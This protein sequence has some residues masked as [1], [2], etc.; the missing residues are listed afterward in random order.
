MKILCY[1]P[2]TIWQLHALWEV[3]ILRAMR[4]RGYTVDYVLCDSEYRDCD[5]F[6]VST[7]GYPRPEMA[8]NLC[9][10]RAA[11]FMHQME[12][13]YHWLGRY[14]TLAE[15]ERADQWVQTL[16]P[17]SF[18]EAVYG[19]WTLGHWVQSSVYTHFRINAFDL[20]DPIQQHV[21][22][23]FLY[24]ALV[25][26]FGISRLVDVSQPD[27]VLLFNGRMSSTRV[28]LEI[29]KQKGIPVFCHE[30]GVLTE[31]MS[32]IPN[33][34][35]TLSLKVFHRYW[36]LWQDLPLR[37]HQIQQAFAY[38]SG[39]EQGK[40]LNWSPFNPPPS[41]D[42]MAVYKF[43]A[44]DPQQPV[45]VFFPS[46][47]DEVIAEK[48]QM[49]PLASQ[50]EWIQRAIDYVLLHPHIQLVIRAHPNIIN[51]VLARHG[52]PGGGS[53]SHELAFFEE[54]AA[55]AYPNIRVILPDA[56]LSSYSLMNIATAGIAP[57]STT[58]LELAMKG[59]A[60][61][62]GEASMLAGAAC[63]HTLRDPEAFSQTLDS[64]LTLSPGTVN[65]DLMRHACRLVYFWTQR[66]NI[67]FPLIKMHNVEKGELLYHH[68]DELLPGREMHLDR[69]C[70]MLMTG[71][72][73]LT[74]S[75]YDRI[76]DEQ[77]E[78]AFFFQQPVA[79]VS[80][81]VLP[82]AVGTGWECSMLPRV[83]VVVL[84]HAQSEYLPEA[85]HSLLAQTWREFEVII[86]NLGPDP[87]V[88]RT[89]QHLMA[90]YP[91]VAMCML[92]QP[93][94]S[95]VALALN[96]AVEQARGT[97]ILILPAQDQLSP[98]Y[99]EHC[100]A[101]LDA[102]P[103]RAIAYPR[104]R[105]VTSR[106]LQSAQPYD[107]AVL[108]HWNYLPDA[109][110]FRRQA[111]RDTG[112]Y[113][114]AVKDVFWDFWVACAQHFHFGVLVNEATLWHEMP[115]V[116]TPESEQACK[117]R[118]AQIVLHHPELYTFH[119]QQWARGVL[120][121]DP[122]Y[123]ELTV[124]SAYVPVFEGEEL[125]ASLVEINQ[126]FAGTYND[127]LFLCQQRSVQEH[128]AQYWQRRG[129]W[130]FSHSSGG[131]VFDWYP[132]L[133]NAQPGVKHLWLPSSA[134]L[135]RLPVA[136]K[137]LPVTVMPRTCF[138]L[139]VP[140]PLSVQTEKS[141]RLLSV[142]SHQ[143]PEEWA[144]FL[145]KCLQVYRECDNIAILVLFPD[146]SVQ[147]AFVY[148]S[149]WL[150]QLESPEEVPELV[151][152]DPVTL[153]GG[154]WVAKLR[155]HAVYCPPACDLGGEVWLDAMQADVPLLCE[156]LPPEYEDWLQPEILPALQPLLASFPRLGCY[157][158]LAN[159][160]TGWNT[161]ILKLMQDFCF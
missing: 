116:Q 31:S 105:E 30:R 151:M 159:F 132:G 118:K 155:P 17:E 14:L 115:A 94:T 1:S 122:V 37:E 51:K 85:V 141:F 8:C 73:G 56:E 161:H 18:P 137:H 135:T 102:H 34:T 86:V 150:E 92:E 145:K 123:L 157:R 59:K 91:E 142:L 66:W 147:E 134:A 98:Q 139:S 120:A 124:E 79:E 82:L 117:Q 101:L 4:L 20:D 84:C 67:P 5:L 108:L 61:L 23:N 149:Q 26:A 107:P 87:A 40:N 60:V 126:R 50:R 42:L 35:T 21:W 104:V 15:R 46:T 89:S 11:T 62:V 70:R 106:R 36:A 96:A 43:L 138:A 140:E 113:Q 109:S 160:A 93:S 88:R 53:N 71:E 19:E 39:R 10:Q 63:A 78:Q 58:A 13:P 38:I 125:S 28:A 57:L 121:Q 114:S 74:P 22:R 72:M 3:T 47:E 25:A 119:Q 33:E 148:L 110:L 24:S 144:L 95:S 127:Q 83:S 76:R 146:L 131:D 32:L 136:L 48:N 143:E 2:Y 153:K 154:Q 100:V 133:D 97:Y 27:T 112:G 49:A 80:Q 81:E 128:H 152:L 103:E 52:V 55:R 156:G 64:F 129:G 9:Q 41:E 12:M 130:W 16:C 54:L 68:L 69:I 90:A 45:W 99:L 77:D 158:P 44:L 6:T 111:W 75:A 65:P 7:F 29:C